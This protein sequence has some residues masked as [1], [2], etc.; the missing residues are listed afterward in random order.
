MISNNV[1]GSTTGHLTK[2][3]QVHHA[4]NNNN[5]YM[6]SSPAA[7]LREKALIWNV[8]LE[9]EEFAHRLNEEDSLS[10]FRSE[11][12]IPKK[13]ELPHVDPKLVD[14]EDE[15]IYLC[16]QSLGLR[17]K[18]TEKYCLEVLNNWAKRGVHS[19]FNGALPAAL[20]DL[21][22]KAPMAK[23]VGALPGEV[24]IMNGLTV[25]L[26]LMLATFYRPTSRRF[27][28]MMEGHAFS[29]DIYA[30][31]SH[32]NFHGYSPETSL[33]LIEPREGEQTLREE[34]VLKLIQ[35]EGDTTALILLP[36]VHYYTGQLM[37]IRK[38]TEAAHSKGIM[39]GLDGAHAVGN[40][41]LYLHD[42]NVDFAV[43]CTYKYLNSGPGCLGAVF[44]HQ[45]L[46]D[47]RD[48]DPCFPMF[49]GWWGNNNKTRFLMREEFDPSVGS[50]MFRISNPPPLLAAPLM[51]S[52]DIF[53]QTSMEEISKKQFLL[54]GYLEYLL[55]THFGSHKP[56]LEMNNG[57]NADGTPFLNIITPSDPTQR[58]SQLSLVFSIPLT[59]VQ[60]SLQK[61]GIVC[62]VRTPNVMRVSPAPLY[63]SFVDVYKFVKNLKQVLDETSKSM[64]PSCILDNLATAEEALANEYSNSNDCESPVS[65]F[66]ST[67]DSEL[68]SSEGVTS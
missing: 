16:G 54:T 9:S 61:R 63:N 60:E 24:T 38:L 56:I 37:N 55:K 11:F 26:H 29:S 15:S 43:W 67:S 41:P 10:R 4:N 48:S 17:P 68:D 39:V 45:R 47:G 31:K 51:A 8:P 58:G 35:K 44:V 2:R 21:P 20:C 65:S 62:D 49:R 52:L 3:K 34:D 22:A 64:D 27:K 30:V 23:L 28:I 33:V 1:S 25:N 59:K 12:C 40:V 13:F 42:W 50:D 32:L 36:G 14:I 7:V 18:Q 19:H 53:D 66:T 46:T 5:G 57:K 6:T